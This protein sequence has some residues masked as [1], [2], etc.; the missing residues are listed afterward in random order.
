MSRHLRRGFSL[1]ELLIV[2]A[3][4]SVLA[5]MVSFQ[6]LEFVATA[7]AR[8][9]INN[10]VAFKKAVN[11][12][13]VKHRDLI[14]TNNSGQY[15]IC[16]YYDTYTENGETYAY[17]VAKPFNNA[18]WHP[19]QEW[20]ENRNNKAAAGRG[21]FKASILQL[22]DGKDKSIKVSGSGYADAVAPL[23]YDGYM[24][25]DNDSKFYNK[26]GR[27]AWFVGY[28]VPKDYM[29]K[30]VR[31]KLTAMTKANSLLADKAKKSEPYNG[32]DLVWMKMLDFES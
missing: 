30:L 2:I 19:V 20:W 24:I 15:G 10:L 22:I 9:V 29:G 16:A 26:E 1:V 11:Y 17:F 23:V 14:K 3:I 32:G 5:V 21:L 31:K 4:I 12:W 8:V 7:R 6:A 27:S 28:A 18:Y 13:V 25:N